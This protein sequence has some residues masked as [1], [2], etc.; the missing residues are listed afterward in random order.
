MAG[1]KT[2]SAK[3]TYL[4]PSAPPDTR[5][6]DL[7]Q[8]M[9]LDEKLRQMGQI[10]TNAVAK[11]GKFSNV[12][13]K[14]AFNDL[15]IGTVQDP[16]LDP[17]TGA[18]L[19][20]DIQTYLTRRTRLGIP[21]LVVSECLHG[22]MSPGAT[23]FPQ[24]IALAGTWNTALIHD[25]AAVAA[26]EARA[27]G[28]AQALSPDLDLAR[29][30]RWGRTEE[31]YGEDP[32]LCER[33]GVA[34]ITGLQGPGPTIDRNHLVATPKH[35]A[36]HGSPESGVNLSPVA[37]G[38]RELR[39]LYLPPFKAAVSEAG[40]LSVMPAYS[41]IDGVPC[42]ASKLLL[43][44]IL[45]EEWGFT[46]YTFSDYGAIGMLADVHHTA[47]DMAEAGKQALEA[48]MDLEAPSINAFGSKLAALIKKG[49]VS[50]DL[51]DQAVLRILRVKFL[52]GLFEN[53]FADLK[54]ARQIVNAPAH[55]KLARQIAQESI[56]L[57]KNAGNLLP[58]DAR[59]LDTIAVIGP[60]A[61][62]PQLGDY[63]FEN[64]NIVTPRQGLRSAVSPGT[65]VIHAR[66]CGIYE[67]SKAGFDQAIDAAKK[68][69]VAILVLG[70]SSTVRYGVGWGDQKNVGCVPTCGEGFDRTDLN[71]PGVQQDLVEAVVATGTPT[72]AV[73]VHGRPYTIPWIAQNVPAILETWY[74]GEQGGNALADVIFGKVNPSGKLPVSIPRTVGQVPVYYN[75]KPSAKGY[76]HNPGTPDKPGQDYVFMPTTP[77]FEFGHGLSYTTFAYSNLRVTPTRI[78]PAGTVNV[79]VTV[80]NTGKREGK[81]VVQLY[82]NDLVSAVT[83]PVKVLRRFE[84]ITLKPAQRQTV[85][86]TLTDKDLSLLDEH[87]R[88][89][90][91]PGTFEVIVGPLTKRFEI[92]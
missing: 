57:L 5:A 25:M 60:N 54:R 72:V 86:F 75:H 63:C 4:N 2:K 29:E 6:R 59:K 12:L 91:E 61:D 8:T 39:Q 10:D 80:R 20:N 14:K 35:Y 13:A 87:M 76:Y 90:V 46:G 49:D 74:A 22:H 37:T 71:L 52:A 23:I 38:A 84:K 28:V 62:T 56:I 85:Q 21:A 41:E 16:R 19:V 81:E 42:S 27:V 43:T 40:A 50:I 44:K 30:P 79:S 24:A 55:R 1:T 31:T 82:V 45:R 53:P 51:I 36:A 48:G 78:R 92:Q 66:G 9:T 89:V 34:Y 18:K 67:R 83:T 11:N 7:L 17:A 47:A 15:S 64:D 69:Q 65:N 73:L 33:M 26:R 3:P 58:L 68:A 70:G 77:L 88:P 32:Y